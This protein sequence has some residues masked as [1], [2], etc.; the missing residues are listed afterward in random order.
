[1][2][3][4]RNT[5]EPPSDTEAEIQSPPTAPTP[6]REKRART[7]GNYDETH[8]RKR[9][10]KRTAYII[11]SSKRKLFTRLSDRLQM[12]PQAI[13]RVVRDQ[14]EWRDGGLAKRRRTAYGARQRYPG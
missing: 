12:G 6:Q 14:Y 1:M 11:K 9:Q 5:P 7:H 13:E 10:K 4:Q 2:R 3:T 8:R